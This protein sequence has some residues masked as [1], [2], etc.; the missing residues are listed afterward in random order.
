MTAGMIEKMHGISITTNQPATPPTVTFRSMP[1]NLGPNAVVATLQALGLN[2]P[3]Q[4]AAAAAKGEALRTAKSTYPLQEID[5]ALS[6]AVVPLSDRFRF[7][8]ALDH[9]GLLGS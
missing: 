9:N 8:A 7:K 4:L 5:A 3:T 6:K 2:I 1:T